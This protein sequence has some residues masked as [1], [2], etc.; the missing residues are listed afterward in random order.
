[1]EDGIDD[2]HTAIEGMEPFLRPKA[3]ALRGDGSATT[4]TFA[5]E[6]NSYALVTQL[7]SSEV[8]PPTVVSVTFPDLDT[9]QAVFST[10]PAVNSIRFVVMG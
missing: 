2:A 7:Y 3:T 9:V 6:L 10:A 4:L 8:T 1:M 5:H